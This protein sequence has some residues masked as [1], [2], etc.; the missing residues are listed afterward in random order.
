MNNISDRELG[1]R[2]YER[3]NCGTGIFDL[4]SKWKRGAGNA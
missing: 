4:C 2:E 3:F 1:R